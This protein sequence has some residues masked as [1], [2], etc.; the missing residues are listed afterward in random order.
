VYV[1]DGAGLAA[2]DASTTERLLGLF[3][4]SHMDY[5]IDRRRADDPEPSL[6]EMAMKAVEI[7][8]ADP[9]GYFLM[10]EGGRIDHALHDGQARRAM[11]EVIAFDEAVRAVASMVDLEDTL[12]LVTGDHDHTMMIGGSP[13]LGSPAITLGGTDENGVPYMSI[14]FGIGAGRMQERTAPPDDAFEDPDYVHESAVPRHSGSHGGADLALYAIGGGPYAKWVSG[15]HD[16]TAV[17]EIMLAAFEGREAL[18]AALQ[19]P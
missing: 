4:D 11:V 6:A 1:E 18:G 19:N 3:D 7:L 17:F 9:D 13:P 2:V 16:N 14:L 5:E 12:I 10:V 15:T 8:A